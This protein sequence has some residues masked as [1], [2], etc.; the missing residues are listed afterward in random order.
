MKLIVLRYVEMGCG[1]SAKINLQFVDHSSFGLYVVQVA[2]VDHKEQRDH[3][4]YGDHENTIYILY[5]Y[6]IH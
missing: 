4:D 2:H 1:N 3:V 5:T 6:Y